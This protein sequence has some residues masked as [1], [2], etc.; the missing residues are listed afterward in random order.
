MEDPNIIAKLLTNNKSPGTDRLTAEFSKAFNKLLSN[1]LFE[2]F[3]ESI[4]RALLPPTL[5]Q[6]LIALIS[7]P[8]KDPLVIDSWR[9]VTL[10]N[11]DYTIIA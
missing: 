9:P 11:N 2:V 6:G 10:L 8:N 1:F 7:K 3:K 5:C 4:E